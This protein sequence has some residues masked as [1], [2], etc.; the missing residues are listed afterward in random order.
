L[1]QRGLTGA[2]AP[3]DASRSTTRRTATRQ[4][5]FI[6]GNILDEARF[7][8][9]A[10]LNKHSSHHASG[11]ALSS[12]TTFPRLSSPARLLNPVPLNLMDGKCGKNCSLAVAP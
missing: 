6:R 10:I 9:Y 11:H 3:D 7:N 2:N 8:Q 12:S 1:F 5:S 4:I